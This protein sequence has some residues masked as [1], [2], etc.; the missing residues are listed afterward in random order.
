MYRSTASRP[1]RS[2]SS[3]EMSAPET[4]DFPPA[5]VR[6]TTRIA[7]SAAKSFKIP[8]ACSHISSETA[9]WRAGLSKIRVPTWPSLRKD[10]LPAGWVG[11]TGLLLHYLCFSQRLDLRLRESRLVQHLGGVLAPSGRHGGETARGPPQSHRLADHLQR[12]PALD[13]AEVL[14]LR[15]GE[16]LVDPVD[17]PAGNAGSVQ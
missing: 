15:I 10:I 17:G 12:L 11:S 5:P 7:S 9:L 13:D 8:A 16:D 2:L 14:D 6:T 1:E 3:L 4:N